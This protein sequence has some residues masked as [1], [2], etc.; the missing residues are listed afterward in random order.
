MTTSHIHY[1]IV[2]IP[3]LKTQGSE[4][5]TATGNVIQN[6]ARMLMCQNAAVA[7]VDGDAR[8]AT[9]TACWS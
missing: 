6:V 4:C 7:T 2:C 5:Y 1:F 3:K 9:S 8:N